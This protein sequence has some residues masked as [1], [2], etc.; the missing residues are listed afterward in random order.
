VLGHRLL[1]P[2]RKQCLR[3]EAALLSLEQD[4]KRALSRFGAGRHLS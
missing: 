2:L 1:Y 4:V 3:V